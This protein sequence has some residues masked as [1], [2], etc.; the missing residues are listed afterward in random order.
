[1]KNNTEGTPADPD[2]PAAPKFR[3]LLNYIIENH[4][5]HEDRIS[6][7]QNELNRAERDLVTES[8]T[9]QGNTLKDP[10]AAARLEEMVTKYRQAN[11]KYEDYLHKY[12]AMILFYLQLQTGMRPGICSRWVS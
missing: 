1:M 9:Q 8:R 5:K 10:R 3:H 2:S 4:G 6:Q 7:A 11:E 12:D